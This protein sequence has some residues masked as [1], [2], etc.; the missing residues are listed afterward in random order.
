MAWLAKSPSG[1]YHV[2]F[3][4]VGEK[5]KK[6]LGTENERTAQGRLSRLE[7]TI[8]LL[9]SGR[10][11]ITER[12]DVATFLLADGKLNGHIRKPTIR[13]LGELFDA[14]VA[15]LADGSIEDSTRTTTKI[16]VKHLKRI[17]GQRTRIEAIDGVKL[18]E[19]V[20]RRNIEE[21]LRGKTVSTKTIKKELSTLG[22]V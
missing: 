6:S 20:N 13:F 2:S 9:E 22:S 12:A 16:H 11:T 3:R 8:S 17:L 18:Q 5:F 4:F 14:Y 1:N 10:L 19:Y 15:Q 21:G 7:E